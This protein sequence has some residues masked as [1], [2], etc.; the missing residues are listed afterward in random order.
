MA[1]SD[2][3]GYDHSALS[4]STQM[5]AAEVHEYSRRT[6]SADNSISI[7]KSMMLLLLLQMM[8]RV[9]VRRPSTADLEA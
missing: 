8:R 2:Q 4:G 9:A 5:M 1:N 6:C 7:Y 3:G